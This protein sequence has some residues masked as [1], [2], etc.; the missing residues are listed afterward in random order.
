MKMLIGDL[1]QTT[2]FNSRYADDLLGEDVPQLGAMRDARLKA[3]R[4][5]VTKILPSNRRGK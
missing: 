4:G 1:I 2:K 5:T 3:T